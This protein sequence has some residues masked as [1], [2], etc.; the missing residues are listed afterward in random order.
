MSGTA[1]AGHELSSSSTQPLPSWRRFLRQG[2]DLILTI[3][4][5][6]MMLLPVVEIFLRTVFKI[7]ISGSSGIVQHLTLMVGMLGGVIAA[8]E[9]R[10][11]ALSPA[12]TFLK[13]WART[14]AQIFS[15]SVAAAICLWL[16]LASVRYVQAVRPLGK[17]LVYGIPVWI[18]QLILPLGFGLIALR[19]LARA[20]DRWSGRG[21]ALAVTAGLAAAAAWLP[22]APGQLMIPA[23]VV[24]VLATLSGAPVFTALGG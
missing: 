3:P 19:L 22:W 2:E 16:C 5:A 4:L 21:V 12:Q 13:G 1:F 18:I 6:T 20:A 24:L 17:I 11:L 14:A 8:R 9:G 23:L 10:L 15:S 7:G